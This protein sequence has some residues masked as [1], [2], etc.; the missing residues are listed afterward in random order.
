MY[1]Y[2]PQTA[3]ARR[4]VTGGAVGVLRHIRSALSVTVAPW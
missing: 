1:R 3:L 4:L 2:H